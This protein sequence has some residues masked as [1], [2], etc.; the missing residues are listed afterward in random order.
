MAL[1]L[2]DD[3]TRSERFHPLFPFLDRR[4]PDVPSRPYPLGGLVFILE[5]RDQVA[6]EL[7]LG[8]CAQP[9]NIQ[10]E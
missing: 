5:H 4:L 10:P 9:A 7:G 2:S 3:K 1:P 8:L 6:C